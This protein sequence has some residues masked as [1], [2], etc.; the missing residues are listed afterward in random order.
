LVDGLGRCRIGTTQTPE[1]SGAFGRQENTRWHAG[2]CF[3][4]RQHLLGHK[5]GRVT[6]HY[7]QAELSKLIKAPVKACDS[8]SRNHLASAKDGVGKW[9]VLLMTF[10]TDR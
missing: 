6:T 7:S 4:D 9:L 10:R 1:L 8:E 3:E 5:S 2:V